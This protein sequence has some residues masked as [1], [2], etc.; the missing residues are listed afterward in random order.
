MKVRYTP[1]AFAELQAIVDYISAHSPRGARNVYARIRQSVDLLKDF[2]HMGTPTDDAAIRRTLAV[3][4]PYV[5]FYEPTADEVV[6]H[7]I[8]HARRRPKPPRAED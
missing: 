3:P 6:I 8:R 4:Y 2:P 7:S 1:A 5:I